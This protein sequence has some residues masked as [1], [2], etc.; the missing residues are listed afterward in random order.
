MQAGDCNQIT[1]QLTTANLK[2]LRDADISWQQRRPVDKKA[3]RRRL[4][5]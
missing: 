3:A 1:V 4:L 2:A 5:A